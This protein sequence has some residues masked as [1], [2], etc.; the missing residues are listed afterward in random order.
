MQVSVPSVQFQFVPLSP[1]A[2]SPAGSVST[3]VTGPSAA[4]GTPFSFTDIVSFNCRLLSVAL[5]GP[6]SSNS[7]PMRGAVAAA[8]SARSRSAEERRTDASSANGG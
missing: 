6:V 8:F 7:K 5:A 4:S 1:V 2:V 3:T